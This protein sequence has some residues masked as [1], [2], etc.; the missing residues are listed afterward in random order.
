MSKDWGIYLNAFPRSD[1]SVVQQ[2]NVADKLLLHETEDSKLKNCLANLGVGIAKF[3]EFLSKLSSGSKSSCVQRHRF[4]V[5]VCTTSCISKTSCCRFIQCKWILKKRFPTYHISSVCQA[6][7]KN[8]GQAFHEHSEH[9]SDDW[10]RGIT[11][12]CL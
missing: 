11:Q 2:Q 7:G 3:S 1:S 8:P 12:S 5:C 9:S 6:A 4:A 10:E